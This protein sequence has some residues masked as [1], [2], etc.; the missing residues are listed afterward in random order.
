ML[1]TVGTIFNSLCFHL[2]TLKM[3]GFQKSLFPFESIFNHFSV[4]V[5]QTKYEYLNEK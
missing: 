4:D 5:R 3:K 1:I 2:S